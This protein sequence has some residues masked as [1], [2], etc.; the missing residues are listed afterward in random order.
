MSEPLPARPRL[1]LHIGTSKTGT[2]TLQWAC[3]SAR[4]RL[5]A[6]GVLYPAL[7]LH[8]PVPKH[9]W[10]VHDL[11]AGGG[12][13]AARL[14]RVADAAAAA[15]A[16]TV[17]LSSEGVYHHWTDFAPAARAALPAALAP[18]D[19]LVW[20]VVREPVAFALSVYAQLAKNP[21]MPGCPYATTEA[22]ETLAENPWFARRLDYAGCVAELDAL[23]GAERVRLSRYED[24][25]ILAQARALL[26]VDAD[27]LPAVPA[28]NRTPTALGIELLRR[29]NRLGLD[30]DERRGAVAQILELDALLAPTSAPLAASPAFAA[31]VR[32]LAAPSERF[33]RARAGIHWDR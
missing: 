29:L 22:P 21:P 5:A 25:D 12:G 8:Q 23:F 24:G 10:L 15:R 1:V 16:H 26:G 9:Q 18:F 32:A 19:V 28:A 13:L 7:D 6:R 27:A 17:L 14:A 3:D 30:G 31:R 11:F 33:L 4:E 20:C 2:T